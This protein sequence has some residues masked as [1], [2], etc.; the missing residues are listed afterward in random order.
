MYVL[1]IKH[2]YYL[3]VSRLDRAAAD[4]QGGLPARRIV[5]HILFSYFVPFIAHSLAYFL[6]IS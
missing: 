5:L 1:S 3:T 6:A 4:D 2:L